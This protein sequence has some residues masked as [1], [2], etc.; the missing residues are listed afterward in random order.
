MQLL[1]ALDNSRG[2]STSG[3]ARTSLCDEGVSVVRGFSGIPDHRV[4]GSD[5][6]VYLFR[7]PKDPKANAS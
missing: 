6:R 2:T 7:H 1:I 3:V 4:V 5:L